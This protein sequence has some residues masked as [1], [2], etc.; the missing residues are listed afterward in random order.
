MSKSVCKGVKV[1][2]LNFVFL[3]KLCVL[4]KAENSVSYTVFH[5]TISSG[6]ILHSWNPASNQETIVYTLHTTAF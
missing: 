5:L 6:D 1:L 3:F 2:L 4:N